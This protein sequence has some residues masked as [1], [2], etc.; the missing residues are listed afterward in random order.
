MCLI[1]VLGF[2]FSKKWGKQKNDKNKQAKQSKAKGNKKKKQ[3]WQ[4]KSLVGALK[5]YSI[6]RK[7]L[8][9]SL[10]LH[11]I[12][13]LSGINTVF[14]YSA[15][16]L[17]SAGVG[18]AWVGSLILAI[19]NFIATAVITP[20]VD[21][22]GR[23]KLLIVSAFGMAISGVALTIS[24]VGNYLLYVCTVFMFVLSLFFFF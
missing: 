16:I 19:A 22:L 6:V 17:Q 14:Y 13:Q 23:K 15:E 12:Q 5:E 18:N 4:G 7:I 20:F 2:L 24:F 1:L 11:M 21:K 9:I 8:I 3:I 10:L